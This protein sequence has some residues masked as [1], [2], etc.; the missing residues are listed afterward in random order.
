MFSTQNC[1]LSVNISS[2]LS[3]PGH[4]WKHSPTK[5]DLTCPH[6]FEKNNISSLFFFF[7]CL[8]IKLK[9]FSNFSTYNW[10]RLRWR[11]HLFQVTTRPVSA[12]PCATSSR[13]SLRCPACPR[14]QPFARWAEPG[15][16]PLDKKLTVGPSGPKMD[17]KYR[18]TTGKN[19]LR[20]LTYGQITQENWPGRHFKA[21]WMWIFHICSWRFK[22]VSI[23]PC[24]MDVLTTIVLRPQ[25]TGKCGISRL[26]GNP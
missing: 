10:Q 12:R 26:A 17:K 18:E 1:W 6:F 4:F 8:A 11:T 15:G 20:K 7:F 25:I 21:N 3:K 19:N 5:N 16:F 14:A 13:G 22:R 2:S 23:H 24:C 9:R